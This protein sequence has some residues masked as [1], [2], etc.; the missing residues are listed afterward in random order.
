MGWA[1]ILG[2]VTGVILRLC[3]IGVFNLLNLNRQDTQMSA[4]EDSSFKG[5]TA[6]TYRAA[7]LQKKM[8]EQRRQGLQ[9]AWIAAN[10]ILGRGTSHDNT[11][12]TFGRKPAHKAKL[13]L[14]STTILEEMSS[15][16]SFDDLS[17]P[18]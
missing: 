2:A 5:H 16:S 13:D 11:T 1:L 18:S 8:Q 3:S 17:I 14:M 9:A 6:A 7:R 10:P 15:T 12:E 4:E